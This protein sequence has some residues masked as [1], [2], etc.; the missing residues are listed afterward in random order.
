MT[1]RRPLRALGLLLAFALVP[2]PAFGQPTESLPTTLT[3]DQLLETARDLRKKNRPDEAIQ[4]C[5]KALNL[6]RSNADALDELRKSVRFALQSQ[7]HRDASF[8]ARVMAMS[9][10]DVLALYAEVLAKIQ[11]HYV[12]LDKVTAGRL[13][14]QGL[15]EYLYSLTDSNFV[16]RHLKGVDETTIARF[17]LNLQKAWTGR[18]VVTPLQAKESV[19]QIAAASKRELGLRAVNPVVCEFICGACNSLDEY[20]AYLSA[21]QYLAESSASPQMCAAPG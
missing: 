17:R 21:G 5:F 11:S 2:S 6:D 13:F 15:D 7:S 19:A 20:S 12:D 14:K 3:V 4:A 9:Q 16:D 10:A 1:Y 8:H 18:D